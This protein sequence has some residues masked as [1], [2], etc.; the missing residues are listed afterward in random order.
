ME[1]SIPCVADYPTINKK[2]KVQVTFYDTA[3]QKT[4]TKTIFFGTDKD[5]IFT[6]NRAEKLKKLG[7]MRQ[8]HNPLS[9]D[10]WRAHICFGS[11]DWV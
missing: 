10:Y 7:F 9:S 3:T 5:F 8:I 6:K 11:D 1:Y 4:A 2:F